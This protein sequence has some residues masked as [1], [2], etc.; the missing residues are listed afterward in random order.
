MDGLIKEKL[1]LKEQIDSLKQNLST[2]I[3]E[4]DSLVET[5]NVFKNESKQKENNYL[6][7]EIDLQNEVKELKNIVYKVGQFAQTVHIL[8]KPQVFYDDQYKQALGYQN[9]FYLKKAQR[10]RPTL[11]DGSV[12]SKQHD[13]I[14]VI[15]DEET[16]IL[17][18]VSRSKMKSK[19]N[20]LSLIEKKV[21]FS[22]INYNELNQ[23]STDFSKCFVPQLELSAEH[24]FWLQN[25]NHNTESSNLTPVKMVAPSELLK[26]SLVN[27]SLKNLKFHLAQFDSVVKT[28]TTPSALTKGEWGFE[29]TK[30]VFINE[31]NP[32]LENL[33]DI[34]NVL[35]NDLLNEITEVKT[36]FNQLEAV[37]DQCSVDKKLFEIEKKEL[38]LENERVL[39]HI[40]C[41]DVVNTVMHADIKSDYV[42]PV[43]NT[44]LDDNIA[45]DVLKM[46]NDRLME[47]LV[48]QDLVHTA[49]NS[50]A[51]INDYKSMEKSYLE[52]YNENLLLKA[53]LSRQ[54]NM[55][56]QDIFIELS[57]SYSKLEKHCISFELV[58]QQS[59]ESFQNDKQCTNQDA[60]EF[61][62][63]FIINELKAQLQA[64]DTTISNLKKHIHELKGKSVA[65]CSESMSKS[66]VIAPIVHN[67]DL[68]PLPP[69][70]KNN[71]EAHVDYIK[72]TKENADTLRDIVEQARKILKIMC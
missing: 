45:L 40:I 51:A 33:K 30:A 48:S 44:F 59:K 5:F 3:K 21:N 2:Q 65:D 12:I 27:E 50:L 13:V 66:K 72:I 43:Q 18:D 37:V 15:D 63:L 28:R 46:E 9:P 8:T 4:K 53:E 31:S 29:H 71:R 60:P 55:I 64:K 47:L 14:P 16:L 32:F 69:K 26:V 57:N 52:E 38:K 25:L 61:R 17:E 36:V 68:E 1:A 39:E 24:A 56:E 70:L 6:D 22:P 49:I 23:L 54:K 34:F 19:Q 58:V 11:Y 67:L 42:L 41:Q 35:D 62:D 7:T 20:D 10:I